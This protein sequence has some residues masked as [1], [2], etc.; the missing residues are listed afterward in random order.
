[1]AALLGAATRSAGDTVREEKHDEKVSLN[2]HIFLTHYCRT[3]RVLMESFANYLK[4]VHNKRVITSAQPPN[5]YDKCILWI[6]KF[7]A[8][9]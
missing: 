4:V 5:C 3:M 8:F 9:F 7:S 6:F 1:M 2:A